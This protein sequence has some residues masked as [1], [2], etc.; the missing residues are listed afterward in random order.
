MTARAGRP[1]PICWSRRSPA[2]VVD[3]ARRSRSAHRRRRHRAAARRPGSRSTSAFE[4]EAAERSMAGFFT[5][6]RLGRPF[7]T[8]KLAMSIDGMI[9]TAVG[10][11]QMDH[12]RGG[13]RPRPS[14]TRPRRHDPGRPRH[15]RGRRAAARR[16]AAG[17]RGPLAAPGAADHRR[18]GRGLD[19]A[20]QPAGDPHPRPTST[21]CWSR[22]ARRPPPPSSP[23]I[24]ST[25]C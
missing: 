4:A 3:R 6:I 18:A 2:R 12:R 20:Q 7:V 23:P 11:E 1:A 15:L 24:W 9:A 13:A 17:A 10:R 22:A 16:A 5:R 8:L 19:P 14:R 25:G 21:I